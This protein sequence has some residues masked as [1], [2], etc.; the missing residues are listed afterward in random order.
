MIAGNDLAYAT[1]T[2]RV[3]SLKCEN[4]Y[5]FKGADFCKMVCRSLS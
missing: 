2:L 5:C 3:S 4:L 1:E